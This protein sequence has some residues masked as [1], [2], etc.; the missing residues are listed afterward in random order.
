MPPR[1]C[2]TLSALAG[3]ALA[4]ATVLA[5]VPSVAHAGTG[6]E[7]VGTWRLVSTTSIDAKG[8]KFTPL[9]A[10]PLGSYTF[11]SSGHFTQAIVPSDKGGRE[12]V[13]AFGDYR[14]IEGG[15]TLVLHLVGSQN[16]AAIG[17]DL[18]REVTL[19]ND[20]LKISNPNPTGGAA[21]V[22]AVWK[23]VR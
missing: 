5:F 16:L 6:S 15:K 17:K 1:N 7:L 11:D 4:F 23:R 21:R 18:P 9:G 14:L 8:T 10:H 22:E 2:T 12:V 3:P 13:A 19:A 20:E